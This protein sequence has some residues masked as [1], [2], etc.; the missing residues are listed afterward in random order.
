M[1]KKV[2]II[3]SI[4]Y[5]DAK[6]AIKWL[7]EAFDFSEDAVHETEDGKVAHAQLTYKG[8]MIMLGFIR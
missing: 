7:C 6:R 8:N 4:S 3:P 1:E 5:Q 2:R